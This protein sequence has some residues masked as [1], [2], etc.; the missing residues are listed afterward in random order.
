ML[1]LVTGAAGFI[2]SHV[3]QR[4]LA[5]GHRVVA[6]DS[7]H[8]YYARTIKERNLEPV[9]RHAAAR[10]V[11]ADLA[12][13]DLASIVEGVDAVVH[14]AAQAGVRASWGAE[15]AGYLDCNVLATQRLLEA[16]KGRPL[17]AWVYGSSASVYG[18]DALDAVAES[19][20]PAPHSPYGVTKLAGE[21]L[22]LLYHR[23]AGTPAVSL[24]YFSV[25]GPRERPDKAIQRFLVAA[26]LG[27]GILVHGDGSQKRDFTYVDDVVDATM[28]ALASP[29]VGRVVNVARGKT[30]TLAEVIETI[31]RVTGALLPVERGPA[32]KGDVR[33]TS[34]DVSLARRLL[35][36]APRTDLAD[37]IA[38]Q[39]AH[40]QADPSLGEAAAARLGGV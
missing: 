40:V 27:R 12:R 8:P 33:V 26:R 9:R 10:F 19:A 22:A 17:R 15:F 34:A 7:F 23:T 37:G 21:H 1:V 24:R 3:A 13:A 30:V 18:D 28:A 32:E 6:V 29:P 35:G 20:L 39:W 16:T 2:G 36:Y 38:R 14:L 31:R 11:E 5:D 25:Y 4:L